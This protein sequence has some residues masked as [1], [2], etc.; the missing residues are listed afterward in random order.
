MVYLYK[1]LICVLIGHGL[2][3]K[4]MMIVMFLFFSC[5]RDS[6]GPNDPL[7]ADNNTDGLLYNKPA[8][9]FSPDTFEIQVD[10]YITTTVYAMG[11][12]NL[13]GVSVI[14]EYDTTKL[15]F[16]N[17]ENGQF[18]S[19]TNS[20]FFVDNDSPG[21]IEIISV[22]ISDD[23]T[24][25]SEDISIAKI[26]FKSVSQGESHL[27]FNRECEMV[28]PDGNEILI[29]HRGTGVIYAE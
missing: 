12:E 26:V 21:I 14:I 3:F 23:A 10:N 11:P 29:R 24:S 20:M 17:I 8:L 19:E 9:I 18:S 28:D 2:R 5:G 1:K 6:S 13:R 27:K 16:F 22:Y 25:I 15:I 4:P 7:E